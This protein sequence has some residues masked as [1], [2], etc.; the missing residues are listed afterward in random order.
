VSLSISWHYRCLAASFY[1]IDDKGYESDAL[2]QSLAELVIEMIAPHRR[3]LIRHEKYASL[4]DTFATLG[5]L[6]IAL[7][8]LPLAQLK[9]CGVREVS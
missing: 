7:R 3:L 5:C 2:D 4:F 9:S 6:M 8:H 1:R